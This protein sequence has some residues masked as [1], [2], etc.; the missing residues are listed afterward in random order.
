[1]DDLV[2]AFPNLVAEHIC[3]AHLDL[4]ALAALA[5]CSKALLRVATHDDVFRRRFEGELW[6]LAPVGTEGDELARRWDASVEDYD[7]EVTSTFSVKALKSELRARGVP[8]ESMLEKSE[9]REAL[10]KARGADLPSAARLSGAW[11]Q[12]YFAT[13]CAVQLRRT[14][15]LAKPMRGSVQ[16]HF[17]GVSANAYAEHTGE[18]WQRRW[19]EVDNQGVLRVCEDAAYHRVLAEVQLAGEHVIRPLEPEHCPDRREHCITID[20]LGVEIALDT[21]SDD[22]R[23]AWLEKM[24]LHQRE[25]LKMQQGHGGPP[26]APDG[27]D[28]ARVGLTQALVPKLRGVL[29]RLSVPEFADADGRG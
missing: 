18:G 19:V 27:E 6:A 11:S 14:T 24:L 23:A 20:N 8:T 2:A 3:A 5:R 17:I 7:D 29:R 28:W 26:S 9:L 16:R 10:A 12:L 1:M 13:R 4:P 15:I 22:N 25:F 21:E